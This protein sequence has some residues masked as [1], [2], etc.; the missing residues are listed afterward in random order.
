MTFPYDKARLDALVADVDARIA[1]VERTA[2]EAAAVGNRA[3][4]LSEKDIAEI[5]RHALGPNAP[6]EMREMVQRIKAGELSWDD[7]LSGRALDDEGVQK[8]MAANLDGLRQAHDA[9]REGQD[10]QDVI[11]A[12][13]AAPRR[14]DDDPDGGGIMREAW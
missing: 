6:K 13:G 1:N 10:P 7:V 11:D 4:G 5:E 8:A 3:P 2:V 9:I 12:L 14:T